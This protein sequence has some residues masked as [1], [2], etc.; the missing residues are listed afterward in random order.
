M[1]TRVIPEKLLVSHEKKKASQQKT[2]L[3]LFP[4]KLILLLKRQRASEPTH[5]FILKTD[6]RIGFLAF[7]D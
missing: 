6:W 3:C 2:P 1:K 7:N 5:A 4:G